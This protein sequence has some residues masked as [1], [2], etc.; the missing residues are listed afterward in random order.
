MDDRDPEAGFDDEERDQGA[1]PTA[2]ASF[3]THDE[4]DEPGNG[5]PEAAVGAFA[6][7]DDHDTPPTIDPEGSDP[8]ERL[9]ALAIYMATE[10][11]DDPDGVEVDVERRGPHVHLSL[12]V[13]EGELGKVIGR[14]GRIAR[15]MR[16]ALMIAGSRANVRASLDI[17]G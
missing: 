3:A 14:Q 4:P 5:D 10:L 17:E 11:V 9:R 1:P 8:V 12:R 2:E 16:T 7:E 13:P 6:D 15:A